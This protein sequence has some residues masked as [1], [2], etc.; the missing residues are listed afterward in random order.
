[1]VGTCDITIIMRRADDNIV[2]GDTECYDLSL[3]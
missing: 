1:M 3:R 2:N